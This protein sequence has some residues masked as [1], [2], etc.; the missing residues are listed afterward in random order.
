MFVI[1]L[2]ASLKMPLLR[3][4]LLISALPSPSPEFCPETD[5]PAYASSPWIVIV[6]ETFGIRCKL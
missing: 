4:P 2:A 1:Q 5:I 6:G 3:L